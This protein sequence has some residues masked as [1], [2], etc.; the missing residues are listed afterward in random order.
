MTCPYAYA[1]QFSDTVNPPTDEDGTH[2]GVWSDEFDLLCEQEFAGGGSKEQ[3]PLCGYGRNG[4]GFPVGNGLTIPQEA[5]SCPPASL[6]DAANR[7]Y[8]ARE[9]NHA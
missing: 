9:M 1:L 4:L 5:D 8:Y 3:E 2:F 6:L 7:V